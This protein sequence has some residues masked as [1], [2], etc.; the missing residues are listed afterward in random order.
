MSVG[1]VVTRTLDRESIDVKVGLFNPSVGDFVLRG[2][3]ADTPS[4]VSFLSLLQDVSAIS[5]LY[6]LHRNKFITDS[7]LIEVLRRLVGR[8][9][10][11]P[12]ESVDFAATLAAYLVD[13]D[14]AD[15]ATGMFVAELDAL[16]SHFFALA[17][18]STMPDVL[19]SFGVYALNNDL[20]SK[21]DECWLPFA[22]AVIGRT[23][24]DYDL[25]AL[26][27]LLVLLEGP[28]HDNTVTE[29]ADHVI[30]CWKEKLPEELTEAEVASKYVDSDEYDLAKYEI[31]EHIRSE[32]ARYS[33]KF[34]REDVEEIMNDYDIFD[35]LRNNRSSYT[36]SSSTGQKVVDTVVTGDEEQQIE[37]LFERDR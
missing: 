28:V 15:P 4:V 7:Q 19:C 16:S 33:I 2:F 13:D 37:D 29:L 32:L 6:S 27:N 24:D 10:S 31:G 17:S 34:G 20:L 30:A 1:A 35:H 36:G 12:F 11:K 21:S 8:F 25:M 26:A 3:A 9:W 14:D 23:N 18:D 22:R 5:Q